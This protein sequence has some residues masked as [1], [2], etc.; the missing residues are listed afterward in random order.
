MTQKKK[1]L[2]QSDDYVK[3]TAWTYLEQYFVADPRLNC[4]H[5]TV[6]ITIFISK[7]VYV[8]Q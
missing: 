6:L 3:K 8:F 7:F 5:D 4:T 1:Q 2:I